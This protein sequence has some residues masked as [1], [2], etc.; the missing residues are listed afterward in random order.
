MTGLFIGG[1]VFALVTAQ[2][3]STQPGRILGR[4]TVQGT[5]APIEGAR[6]MLIPS[7]MGVAR[8]GPPPQGVT[9]EAGRFVL[10]SLPP[11]DYHISVQK[12]GYVQ[13]P[14]DGANRRLQ[15]ASG[16]AIDGLDIQ[17]PKG[18]VIAGR[19]LDASGAP[20]PDVRVMAMRHFV[21]PGA[22][23]GVA[24]R[25]MPA[26]AQGQQTNDVGEFRLSG[27]PAGEY[28]V[29]AMRGP[30]SVFG[31]PAVTPSSRGVAMTTTY[32]PGT[33][34][35]AAAQ[36]I[37]IGP[38]E[39]ATGIEFTMQSAPAYRVSG[40]VMDDNGPVAGAMIMLIG[41]PRGGAF[42]GPVGS[43]QSD[44]EGRF[45][46]VDVPSGTFRLSASVP[47]RMTQAGAGGGFGAVTWS[48][49][50]LGP[51]QRQPPTEVVVTDADV[52]GVRITIQR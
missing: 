4:V 47:V 22:P 21:P 48:S 34:N 14:L 24:P 7:G 28:F 50:R 17:L 6:V 40:R 18:A 12:T 42:T 13:Y 46:I 15:I 30:G 11:G 16:Q 49:E 26:P 35:D 31:G 29:A 9:D 2:D 37:K 23:A 8:S 33:V 44:A 52:T 27:L 1:L 5:G 43:A 20:L 38:G 32:Y 25:L 19:V 41:D 36:P 45:T 51:G 3:A 39:T 10:Q